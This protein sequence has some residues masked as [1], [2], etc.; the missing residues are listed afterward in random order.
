VSAAVQSGEICSGQRIEGTFNGSRLPAFKQLDMRF[1]KGLSLG[2]L[3]V[4]AYLDVRNILNL[5]NVLQV[6]A[7]TNNTTSAEDSTRWFDRE[8]GDLAGEAAANGRLNSSTGTIDL[9]APTVCQNWV[10]SDAKAAQP[11]CVYL[12]RAEQRWGNGDGIYTKDEQANAIG[13]FY[14]F[15][16]GD[17]RYTG[18]PRRA[19]VGLEVNF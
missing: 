12:I 5:R 7:V 1:T 18:P 19:R 2:R 3:D 11:S 8:F 16:R 10:G 4:T 17:N 9:S 14:D 13:A 6:F 15:S